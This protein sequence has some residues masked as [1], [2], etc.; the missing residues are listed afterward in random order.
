MFLFPPRHAYIELARKV[1]LIAPANQI[2][3]LTNNNKILTTFLS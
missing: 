3:A 2:V 1:L